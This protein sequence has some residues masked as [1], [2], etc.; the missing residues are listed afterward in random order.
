MAL[1]GPHQRRCLRHQAGIDHGFSFPLRY[2]EVHHLAPDWPTFLEDFQRHWPTDENNMYVDFVREGLRGNGADRAGNA[3][4]RR[5]LEGA[6]L[7]QDAACPPIADNSFVKGEDLSPK[8]R[9]EL[10]RHS[11]LALAL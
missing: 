11:Q 5:L 4:W 1:S 7:A 3:R 10:L 2:F 9:R 8:A 6:G